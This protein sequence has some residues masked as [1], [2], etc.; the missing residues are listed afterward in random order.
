LC[1]L[2]LLLCAPTAPA[3][4]EGAD[5]APTADAGTVTEVGVVRPEGGEA[6]AVPSASP[7]A[8]ADLPPGDQEARL[9][10]RLAAAV[11]ALPRAARGARGVKERAPAPTLSP[12][13]LSIRFVGL[14]E[15]GDG[16]A[17]ALLEAAH[18]YA[19]TGETTRQL[20]YL[21]QIIT[22]YPETRE[23]GRALVELADY[24]ERVGER[25]T[26]VRLY[27]RVETEYPDAETQEYML[28][29]QAWCHPLQ[30]SS[31]DAAI[32]TFLD[33]MEHSRS[34]ANAAFAALRLADLLK[35]ELRDYP[36]ALEL[37]EAV[38]ES[39][40]GTSH[41]REALIG[42]AECISWSAEERHAE[43]LDIYLQVAAEAP[44]YRHQA[45][46]VFGVAHSLFEL[47]DLEAAL[48]VYSQV[49]QYYPGTRYADFALVEMAVCHQQRRDF[50]LALAAATEFLAGEE[51]DPLYRS[52]AHYLVGELSLRAEDLAT[53]EEEF[54]AALT[55]PQ[56]DLVRAAS[57]RGLAI[58]LEMSGDLPAALEVLLAGADAALTSRE[59][60]DLLYRAVVCAR[61]MGD[62]A[63][64]EAV[65][66]RMV[67]EVPGSH[68][69]TRL[70]GHEV[71]PPPEI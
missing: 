21:E 24:Y 64:A 17:S 33:S 54:R 69:T 9:R 29:A 28:L 35:Y 50:D 46:A 58:C 67:A 4:A 71:L 3:L 8:E 53:A 52:W 16:S 30:G 23:A 34:S 47:R 13:G 39:Y 26:A 38:A 11:A 18:D 6:V 57:H 36:A 32:Y 22:G 60:A 42:I 27:G 12:E 68:L 45:R 43:A 66:D 48:G 55:L 7:P 51:K 63:T 49:R 31:Y 19:W 65:V 62:E 15:W 70:V 5:A 41:E 20:A 14:G 10:A 40:P 59:K 25:A 2:S 37:Y 44:E 61:Q 56:N 1:L